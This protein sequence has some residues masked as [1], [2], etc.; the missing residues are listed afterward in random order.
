MLVKEMII[1]GARKWN[2]EKTLEVFPPN[3][4]ANILRV[5]ILPIEQIDKLIWVPVKNDNLSIKSTYKMISELKTWL[6][7]RAP[8]QPISTYSGEP[9]G[10]QQ[11]QAK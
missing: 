5:V 9:C 3:V 2:F 1:K 10:R 11:P 7:G 8:T 6:T 4:T